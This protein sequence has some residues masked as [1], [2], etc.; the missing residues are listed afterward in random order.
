MSSI[1]SSSFRSAVQPNETGAITSKENETEQLKKDRKKKEEEA[2]PEFVKGADGAIYKVEGDIK[3]LV[4]P[5]P[6]T[7]DQITF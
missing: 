4:K 6:P 3:T 5:A 2:A 1:G 7:E